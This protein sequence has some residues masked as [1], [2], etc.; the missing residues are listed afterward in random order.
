ML[1]L[2]LPLYYHGSYVLDEVEAIYHNGI[3]KSDVVV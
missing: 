2:L 1:E 3:F